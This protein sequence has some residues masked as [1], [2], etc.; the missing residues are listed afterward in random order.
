M[1]CVQH[2]RAPNDANGNPQRLYL[3]FSI[4]TPSFVNA[5]DEGYLG[6]DAIPRAVR[7]A[8]STVWLPAINV[9]VTEYRRLLKKY[10]DG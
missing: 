10:R 3:V 9:G 5:Y 2:I 8:S 6:E 7:A 4:Y 1:L